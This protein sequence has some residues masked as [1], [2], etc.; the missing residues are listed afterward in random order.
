MNQ[1]I[2]FYVLASHILLLFLASCEN[3]SALQKSQVFELGNIST[4]AVEYSTTFSKTGSEVYFAR[5]NGEWGKGGMKSTIYYSQQENGKWSTPQVVS[6][7]GQYNDS[8][9]HLSQDGQSLYFISKRPAKDTLPI[10][11]DIW[12]IKKEGNNQ[13]G[14]PNKLSVPINSE[15]SEFSP[16]TDQYGNLYFASTRSGGYGQGDLY[17]AKRNKDSFVQPINLGPTINTE[18]GEWNLEISD[19]GDL[20]IFEASGREQSLSPYGDFYISFKL[21]E[22]WSVPQPIKEINT[23][24][25]DL[26]ADILEDQQLLYYTSSDSLKSTNTN[27][28]VM[29][30]DALYNNY[31]ESAML[32]K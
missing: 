9:P 30:W 18:Q 7:S 14:T 28:Y 22:Q 15:K 23:T 4:E 6:F 8:D 12:V 11:S 1:P 25:S 10:S 21:N 32:P 16:R 17:V 3:E 19:N 24:G 13:W 29:G 26:Y 20:L 5:S 2:R 27:I 31:R